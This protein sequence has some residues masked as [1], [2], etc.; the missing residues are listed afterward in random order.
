MPLSENNKICP[1]DVE[2]FSGIGDWV[3]SLSL[4]ETIGKIIKETKERLLYES[5]QKEIG[6]GR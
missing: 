3:Q 5:I 4:K 1:I 2:Y 6:N